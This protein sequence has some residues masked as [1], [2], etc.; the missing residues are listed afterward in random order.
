MYAARQGAVDTAR[1]LAE[2]GAALDLKDPEGTTALMFA[3][4]NAHYDTAAVLIEKGRT[5]MSSTH[6]GCRRSTLQS[7]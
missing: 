4:I 5:R 6:P 7:T 1:A 2:R 3:I